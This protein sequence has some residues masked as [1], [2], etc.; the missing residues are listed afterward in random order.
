MPEE[1]VSLTPKGQL[2]TTDEVFSLSK[3][4]VNEGVQ[5]IRLTGGEPLLRKDIV[6]ICGELFTVCFGNSSKYTC[7]SLLVSQEVSRSTRWSGS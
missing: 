7:V 5:K 6:T 2:L 3:L 1:G 4:F